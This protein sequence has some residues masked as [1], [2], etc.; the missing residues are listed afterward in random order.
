LDGSSGLTIEEG[1]QIGANVSIFTHSSHISIRLFGKHYSD[2][3]KGRVEDGYILKKVLIGKY[4]FI[5]T[6]SV[7]L[8]GVTIG[9]G[10]IISANA[11]VNKNVPDYA[12][13]Q[14]NPAEIIGDTRR[15]D[16]RYLK[17]SEQFKNYYEEWSRK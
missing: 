10:C 3:C 12:I 17:R 13:V 15:L 14:G 4:T 16:S 9:K 6:G 7:I 1:C 8:P 5:A 2:E 11:L